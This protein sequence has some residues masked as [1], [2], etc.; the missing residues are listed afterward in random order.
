ML[1]C[2]RQGAAAMVRSRLAGL[3]TAGL[4]AVPA[5]AE[6]NVTIDIDLGFRIERPE[7]SDHPLR[8]CLH[9]IPCREHRRHDR[10]YRPPPPPP[11]VDDARAAIEAGRFDA[12]ERTLRAVIRRQPGDPDA[13]AL[14]GHAERRLGRIA[15]A[16]ASLARALR[17]DPGNP[18][19]L[20]EQG[21]LFLS[22]G[23]PADARANLALLKD[24]CGDCLEYVM[25]R[26]ALN[27]AGYPE[28]SPGAKW[29]R[30]AP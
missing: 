26:S 4:L 1:A 19:A 24:G 15:D 10:K 3:L 13:W 11:T 18:A 8:Y 21:L 9:V 7:I 14:L 25:L 29:I 28:P 17:I 22:T 20:H 5:G 6:T 2:N 23:A 30:V 16:K 27:G 12:A